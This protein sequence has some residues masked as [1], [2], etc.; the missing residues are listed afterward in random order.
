MRKIREVGNQLLTWQ[1]SEV[2]KSS[3]E[4]RSGGDIVGTVAWQNPARDGTLVVATSAD[5]P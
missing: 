1:P 4:L 5:G 2:G 3:W